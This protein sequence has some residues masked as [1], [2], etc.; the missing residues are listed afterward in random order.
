M[1][2]AFDA[3]D[4]TY[5]AVVAQ[6]VAF[7]GLPYDFFV[8]SKAALLADIFR[9][10]FGEALPRVADIGCGV[11]A[12]HRALAPISSQIFGCDPS[13]ECLAQAAQANPAALYT[14]ADASA[15]PWADDTVD[16]ALAVCVM[17]HIEKP[18]RLAALDEMR[19]IV[20]P[21]G[22]VILIEHNPWNP[23]TQLAVARCPF[24]HDA[25]LL[26]FGE[27]KKLLRGAGLGPVQTR[28]FLV[29]PWRAPWLQRIER[30][31]SAL[32]L[33]AQFAAI[34]AVSGDPQ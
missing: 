17:H 14:E 24:D 25:V 34:A 22:L 30:G 11:G 21:G 4:Q 1:S 12:L 18:K 7:S 32:P 28:H 10:H 33:G 5:R 29:S 2:A 31:L 20:R 27:A 6:S 16:A 15:L 26:D 3:Y 23:L 8:A 9:V 13:R 19:R